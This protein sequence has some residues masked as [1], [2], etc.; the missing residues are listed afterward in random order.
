MEKHII[1]EQKYPLK[2]NIGNK[3][4]DF[5][6]LQILG[7]GK[8]GFVS[9]VKSKINQKIYAMKMTDISLIKDEVEKEISK[10]EIEIIN[11]LDSPHIIKYYGYFN[12]GERYYIIMEFINNGNIKDYIFAYKDKKKNNSR[13]RIMEIILSMYFLTCL[14]S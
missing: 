10:N 4:E 14:Y 2:E 3:I 11:I 1:L 6:I 9:K 13:R 5:E 8:Y 7:K 12:V